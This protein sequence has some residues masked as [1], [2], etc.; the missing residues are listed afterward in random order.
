MKEK[1]KINKQLWYEVTVVSKLTLLIQADG[2]QYKSSKT[3]GTI[4]TDKSQLNMS[5]LLKKETF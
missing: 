1:K 5:T 4:R 2:Y 3:T